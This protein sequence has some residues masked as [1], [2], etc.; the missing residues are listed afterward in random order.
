[1]SRKKILISCLTIIFQISFLWI[2]YHF[3]SQNIIFSGNTELMLSSEN[4]NLTASVKITG[5]NNKTEELALKPNEPLYLKNNWIKELQ[6]QFSH[7]DS[8]AKI[9]ITTNNY[10]EIID[11][12]IDTSLLILNNKNTDFHGS[13]FQIIISSFSWIGISGIMMKI[14]WLFQLLFIFGIIYYNCFSKDRQIFEKR[15][16]YS[17]LFLVILFIII[18]Y[19]I[20][21]LAASY[22]YPNAEDL[23]NAITSNNDKS[24]LSTAFSYLSL[25]T[26]FTT[27]LIYSFSPIKFWGVESYKISAITYLFLIT[28]STYLLFQQL[29]KNYFKK[30]QI[31]IAACAFTLIHFTMIHDVTYDLYYMASSSVYLV[32][33]IAI[34]M[35]LALV[36]KWI[37]AKSNGS[38]SIIGIFTQIVF[39]LSFGLNEMNFLINTFIL[40]FVSYYVLKYNKQ[41]KNELFILYVLFISICFFAFMI[42]GANTRIGISGISTDLKSIID[43]I[44]ISGI[45]ITKTFFCWTFTNVVYIPCIILST[46]ILNKI[47]LKKDIVPFSTKEILVFLFVSI[48]IIYIG[49]AYFLFFSTYYRTDII[50][51][52]AL[53]YLNWAYQIIVL[54]VLPVLLNRTISGVIEK[55]YPHFQKIAFILLVFTSIFIITGKNNL[56]KIITE[57]HS[58]D[59]S[60]F[61]EQMNK[62]YETIYEAQ[63]NEIWKL[64][65]VDELKNIPRTIYAVPDIGYENEKIEKNADYSSYYERFFKIDEIR[66]VNDSTTISDILLDYE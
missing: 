47:S 55:I 50:V 32:S 13:F 45:A 37:N 63:K 26:R 66:L 9:N 19:F 36:I 4:D 25:D 52:R 43:S 33:W 51:F 18:G 40:A 8:N 57:H 42:P 60:Y 48:L 16:N 49:Y 6:I 38:K 56:T 1:M 2:G 24:S 23:S 44:K 22:T 21:V 28:F 34:F 65:I 64:A 53:N 15:L 31:A 30:Y 41:F 35:W 10:T 59:Y 17:N 27:N 58:G 46:L 62:R 29:F 54:I 39:L 12:Q 5:I 14:F 11:K 7:I 3:I 20:L 61:K